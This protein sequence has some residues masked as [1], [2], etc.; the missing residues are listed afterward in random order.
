MKIIWIL[1]ESLISWS[2]R[3]SQVML[4]LNMTFE[5]YQPSFSKTEFKSWWQKSSCTHS[6]KF[7]IALWNNE[8]VPCNLHLCSDYL[9]FLK[10]TLKNLQSDSCYFYN[11]IFF[12]FFFFFNPEVKHL[13]SLLALVFLLFFQSLIR[14]SVSKLVSPWE[15]IQFV[16]ICL[17][18]L[19]SSMTFS[20]WLLLLLTWDHLFLFQMKRTFS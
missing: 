18:V 5:N 2:F 9:D 1:L 10:V 7:C 17:S 12:F 19:F 20:I 6:Y 13:I 16:C 4:L 8:N 11:T 14:P 15:W 3:G